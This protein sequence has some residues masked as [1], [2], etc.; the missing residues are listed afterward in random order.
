MNR[1]ICGQN[2]WKEK[3]VEK[4]FGRD[5]QKELKFALGVAYYKKGDKTSGEAY[6]KQVKDPEITLSEFLKTIEES[7][8]F[9]VGEF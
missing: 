8:V 5:P 3:L 1:R 9:V 6:L 2:C 7:T 4:N